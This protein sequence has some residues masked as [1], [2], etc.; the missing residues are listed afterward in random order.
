MKSTI[1]NQLEWLY[2]NR[3]CAYETE[4]P[5][6]KKPK[7]WHCSVRLLDWSWTSVDSI[8]FSTMILGYATIFLPENF[9]NTYAA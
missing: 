8:D 5:D 4:L 6:G 9:F 1:N 2:T 3:V 7:M